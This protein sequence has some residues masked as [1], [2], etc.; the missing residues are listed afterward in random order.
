MLRA[1]ILACPLESYA[2]LA[3][4]IVHARVEAVRVV[5]RGRAL[6]MREVDLTILNAIKG[7]SRSRLSVQVIGAQTPERTVLA[8][9]APELRPGE[10]VVLFLCYDRDSGTAGILGLSQGT[11]RVS[12][13]PNGLVTV[14]GL[15]ANQEGLGAF[16]A[17]V[18][19]E[20]VR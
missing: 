19:E 7:E 1:E 9:D 11:Y 2:K 6:P 17:R 15:H 3:D 4:E 20:W 5:Q 8:P 12:E 10:E 18:T 14:S 16:F 13:G